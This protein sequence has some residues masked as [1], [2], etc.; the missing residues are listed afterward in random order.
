MEAIIKLLASAETKDG[1]LRA[2]SS[3]YVG[4]SIELIASKNMHSWHVHNSKGA[5][6]GVRV[7]IKGKR[8]RFESVKV[9]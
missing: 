9:C 6:D 2:I 8:Y 7:V 4:S 5:I 3:Y 1:I